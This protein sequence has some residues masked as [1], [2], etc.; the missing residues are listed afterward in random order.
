MSAHCSFHYESV[1]DHVCKVH[2]LHAHSWDYA[3]EPEGQVRDVEA[4]TGS[5]SADGKG[6]ARPLLHVAHRHDGRVDF[7]GVVQDCISRAH[8][9]EVENASHDGGV[10][11]ISNP[12]DVRAN[13]SRI[14]GE[15]VVSAS[16]DGGV[17]ESESP[18][19]GVAANESPLGHESR[20]E[21]HGEGVS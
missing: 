21:R 11:K 8:T 2:I 4:V 13:V 7:H 14:D 9:E 3:C 10:A 20:C 12:N 6:S 15:A 17:E 18:C 5:E 19:D 16:P 1:Y